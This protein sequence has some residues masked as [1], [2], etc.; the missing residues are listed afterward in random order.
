MSKYLLEIGTEELPYRFIP[1]AI[2]QL[3]N[4]FGVF[5][6][7]NKVGYSDIN[8]YATPR[9]LAVIIDG[10]EKSS[11]DEVKIV[12]GPVK[13]VAYDESGNLSK[14]GLGFANK[15]GVS[16]EDLYIEDD[17][18]HAKILI[19][20]KSIIEL[21]QQNVPALVLK[22]QGSHFMRWA[23]NDQKFSRPIRWIVSILDKDEVKIKIIDKESSNISRGHRFAQ[24]SVII[25]HPDDYVELMRNCCVIV[26]QNERRQRII[27]KAK[28]EAEKFGAEPYYTDDLLDE[29]TFITEY[30]VPAVCDFSEEYL[31][32]PEELVVTVMAVH[33]RY[34]ALYK[35]GKL[36]NKFITMTNY[37]GDEFENIK[38]G[39][40]RVIKA[41][42]DDAVFFFNEDTKKPLESYVEDLKGITFQKG[43]GSMYDKAQR[44]VSLSRTICNQL[45]IVDSRTIERTALLCK[46]DLTTNLVFEFTELQGY[47]GADYA[48]VSGEL[49]AVCEGIKEHYFPLNAESDTA[50]TIEGQ[51]V[52]IADKIDTIAAVFAEGKKPTGSSDPL[53]V[54]RAA[55]GIIRTVLANNLNINLTKLVDE[56]L[57]NLPVQFEGGSIV[58]KL[59]KAADDCVGRVSGKVSEEIN[60]FIIQR[61]IIYLSD[62]YSKNVLEA[63][64]V[65]K[66][67][68]E[69]LADYI[70]RVKVISTLNCPPMLESA[71]RV[72]RLLKEPVFAQVNKNLFNLPAENMLLEQINTVCAKDNYAEY[73]KQLEE[74]NPS[75]EKFFN[76]VLVMDKDEKIKQ[77]RLALLALLKQK[78][79]YICDFCKL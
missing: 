5:L 71:N 73:L 25:G 59:K 75:V 11:P 31:K 24:Q 30:P 34:F 51:V 19:K 57:L 78:Y 56:T 70:E 69:N 4:L 64:A 58:D 67:P 26:D 38:A 20:G 46:A 16:P 48:R 9:R 49:D 43:M 28:E 40:V 61:L 44:L 3:E 62:K 50:K 17:Y 1:S 23:D 6:S 15:N 54:R 21:L 8:V 35:D 41:R 7:E 53:G 12:K 2:K 74:I 29:V 33:Q 72:A 36:I 65:N 13:R 39:N 10:L 47:I 22:L 60:D 52:G 32:L 76:D 14:A 18:L 37:L 55:L 79:D 42:L 63:C 27:E 77:N 45:G 66:N 68:L